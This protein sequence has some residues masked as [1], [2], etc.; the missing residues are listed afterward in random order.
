MNNNKQHSLIYNSTLL[1]S[2]NLHTTS[3]SSFFTS[4]KDQEPKL[5]NLLNNNRRRA[6]IPTPNRPTIVSQSIFHKN[7]DNESTIN[8][9]TDHIDCESSTVANNSSNNIKQDEII[10]S[11]DHQ[12]QIAQNEEEH[13]FDTFILQHF[14]PFSGKQSV[15]QW[16]DE[17]ES[18]FNQFKISR[19]LRFESISLLVEG[20]AKRFYIKNRNEIRS[21]DDFYEFLLLHFDKNSSNSSQEQSHPTCI[22]NT[23]N[24]QTSNNAEQTID[25]T[26]KSTDS[27]DTTTFTRP[28]STQPP[29]TV[30]DV[31][32]TN[33][34]GEI[35]DHKS[36][37]IITNTPTILLDQT[38]NDLRK[39]I[40]EDFV[41]NP[42]IFKGGK[43]NVNKWIEDIEHM[44]DIAHV[45]DPSRLD[46]ISY[47]LRGDALQWYKNNK[48]LFTSWSTFIYEI[49][50]TFTSSFHEELAFKKLESYTQGENQSIRNFFNEVL[51][52]CK[53]ADPT[54][55]ETT[56]LKNLL[57]KTK[58]TIQFEVRKKKPTTT[59]EFLEYAK[60]VEDLFQLS[61]INIDNNNSISSIPK[62]QQAS[63]LTN[64]STSGTTYYNNSYSNKYT[65]E[66]SN[67]LRNNN[68]NTFTNRTNRHNPQS[69]TFTSSFSRSPQSSTNQ[70]RITTQQYPSNKYKSLFNNTSSGQTRSKT[71]QINS[72]SANQPRQRTANTLFSLDTPPDTKLEQESFPSILCP[73]CN[74]FGHE[75][76]SCQNF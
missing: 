23:S 63:S 12:L 34:A 66:Y 18:K 26:E 41:K 52:L 3:T 35:L 39:A 65:P 11:R 72:S 54:M 38:T 21:Y 40:L 29:T 47:S 74:Q 1:D 51:K 2:L 59:A 46:L 48:T 69:S 31:G 9:I 58:S 71:Y 62:G 50:R 13:H 76:S 17:T 7:P 8:T 49:K 10:T 42:K 56:K 45:P 20:D 44:L 60:D 27:Y 24:Q 73:Q 32:A 19:H 36:T 67:K 30:V 33:I 6:I 75:A 16:L 70:S 55:S 28:S 22:I 5:T 43:D 68:N 37:T 25:S 64:V 61:N 53:E 15:N 57:N 4:T 14:V